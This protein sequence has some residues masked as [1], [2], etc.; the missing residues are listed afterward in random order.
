MSCRDRNKKLLARPTRRAINV[1][2]KRRSDGVIRS[3][4]EFY[5]PVSGT[6]TPG[7]PGFPR[8]GVE[9]RGYRF[10]FKRG[11][12][13]RT[14]RTRRRRN[15]F[16]FYPQTCRVVR[17]GNAKPQVARRKSADS[18]SGRFRRCRIRLEKFVFFRDYGRFRIPYTLAVRSRSRYESRG[19]CPV[20]RSVAN[21]KFVTAHTNAR[22]RVP[23]SR[24][25]R[26][27]KVRVL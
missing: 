5:P 16:I 13:R 4:D 21:R 6:L 9:T 15:S 18:R 19:R 3:R 25:S 22:A 7:R 24:E 11:D 17:P 23:H 27:L 12:S 10:I 1:A 2:T 20:S 14:Q 8:H 26:P